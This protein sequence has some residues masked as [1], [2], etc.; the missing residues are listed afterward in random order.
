MRD[1]YVVNWVQNKK[2]KVSYFLRRHDD[3]KIVCVCVMCFFLSQ[4]QHKSIMGYSFVV[5]IKCF[6]A[7]GEGGSCSFAATHSTYYFFF[8]FFLCGSLSYEHPCIRDLC[9]QFYRMSNTI[10]DH[11]GNYARCVR[12]CCNCSTTHHLGRALHDHVNVVDLGLDS[13]ELNAPTCCS[14]SSMDRLVTGCSHGQCAQ[15]L[16]ETDKIKKKQ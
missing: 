10:S 7:V 4:F 12:F 1:Y 3:S 14:C 9:D 6:F 8:Y 13:C 11:L 16:N 2:K 15:F 5:V